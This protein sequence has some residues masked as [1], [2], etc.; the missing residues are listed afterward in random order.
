MLRHGGHVGA[1]LQ[2]NFNELLLLCVPTWPSCSL[3]FETHRT[4]G[5]VTENH[6]YILV[7]S[8]IFL[9]VSVPTHCRYS[10]TAPSTPL[11]NA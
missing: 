7:I 4:E 10:L 3:S 2:K 5:H 9:H 6:L 1:H 8:E 11:T